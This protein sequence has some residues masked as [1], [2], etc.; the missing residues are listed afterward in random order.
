M[1]NAKGTT[2]NPG[3]APAIDLGKDAL[4]ELANL[5]LE[6][7]RHDMLAQHV[8][9]PKSM[10]PYAHMSPDAKSNSRATVYRVVQALVM[11]GYIEKP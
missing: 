5:A 11:L 6:I 8:R 7:S 10:T 3:N 9:P 4:D 1:T 2:Q